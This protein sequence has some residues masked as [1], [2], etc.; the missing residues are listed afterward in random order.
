VAL[1]YGRRRAGRGS[2]QSPKEE[3]Q[4]QTRRAEKT[5]ACGLSRI[6]RQN[7]QPEGLGFFSATAWAWRSRGLG[8][9]LAY[10]RRQASRRMVRDIEEEAQG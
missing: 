3:A 8:V 2:V 7:L 10:G 9:A 4:G 5:K 1:A 6:A